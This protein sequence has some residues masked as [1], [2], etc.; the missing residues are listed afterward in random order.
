VKLEVTDKLLHKTALIA[1]Q[2]CT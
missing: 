2:G 1:T